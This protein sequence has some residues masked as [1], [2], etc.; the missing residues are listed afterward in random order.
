MAGPN[1]G[2]GSSREHAVWALLDYGFQAVVSPGFADIFRTNCTKAGLL[3]VEVERRGRPGP[4][5]RRQADPALEVTVDVTARTLDAPAAGIATTFPLDDFTRWRLLEGLDDIGLTLRHEDAIATY[6]ATR[7]PGCRR[8]VDAR[9]GG[10]ARRGWRS[11]QDRRRERIQVRAITAAETRPLRHAVLRPGQSFEQT[12]YSR[13]DHPETLHL[14]AFDGDRL[15]A[16]ASLYREARPHRPSR[17]AWRL[18]G[19]ATDPDVRGGGFGDGACSTPPSPTWPPREGA[20]CGATPG[21][22]PS[23]STSATASRSTA[24]SSRSTG[25]AST[26]W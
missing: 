23:A 17:A 24:T 21:C 10:V 8:P 1:F 9:P 11:G 16:I 19:M 7:R 6:E 4:A 15:V 13:D 2:T 26:S 3:P 18:R 5:R 14:G 12:V 25:S 20:S 22:P